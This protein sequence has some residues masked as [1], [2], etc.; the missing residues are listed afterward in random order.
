MTERAF[1]DL[2]SRNLNY[3]LDLNGK[4]QKDLA[5]YIGVSTSSVSS[6]CKGQKTPRMDKVDKICSFFWYKAV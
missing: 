3:F 6:W 5:D 1:N 4:T 2:F